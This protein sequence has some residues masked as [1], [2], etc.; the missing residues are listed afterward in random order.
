MIISKKRRE[1]LSWGFLHEKRA[2]KAKKAEEHRKINKM[3]LMKP[4]PVKS[5]KSSGYYWRLRESLRK[6]RPYF[7][8]SF[9]R[10]EMRTECQRNPTGLRSLEE[11]GATNN[12]AQD[13]SQR[14]LPVWYS[15]G[16]DD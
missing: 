13:V 12:S 1:L 7:S 3:K 9:S 4:S 15:Q 11:E 8:F 5:S 2:R 14:S 16:C 10:D 6:P